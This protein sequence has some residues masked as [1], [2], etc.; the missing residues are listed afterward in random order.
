MLSQQAKTRGIPEL[1]PRLPLSTPEFLSAGLNYHNL[2]TDRLSYQA[3]NGPLFYSCISPDSPQDFNIQIESQSQF[4]WPGSNDALSAPVSASI[5]NSII[6]SGA[7]G[8]SSTL[9]PSIGTDEVGNITEN[10]TQ[11][12]AEPLQG[13]SYHTVPFLYPNFPSRETITYTS[14]QN[15]F[16]NQ[17]IQPRVLTEDL[18]PNSNHEENFPP[19][20][21]QETT[22]GSRCQLLEVDSM[23]S[24]QAD[25]LLDHS[26]K[27][28]TPLVPACP[29]TAD[30]YANYIQLWRG[31]AFT[32]S[33]YIAM[34][35]KLN[36][37]YIRSSDWQ[38]PFY[39]ATTT[40]EDDPATLLATAQ[41]PYAPANLQPTLP[42]ILFPHHAY[43][44]LIPFPVFRA[45]AITL[46]NTVHGPH[47]DLWDLKRD[48]NAGLVCWS[49]GNGT[50]GGNV[51]PWDVRSWKAAP[52]FLRKWRMLIE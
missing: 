36:I 13:T 35:L 39:R 41:V 26:V 42:Q 47:C 31:S 37:E 14:N 15:S 9:L 20:I 40:L 51:Q 8:F 43:L 3:V 38:S 5:P 22:T 18:F 11:N 52:W 6:D 48:I 10:S 49:P 21:Q 2:A 28:V 1:R 33:L 17:D 46:A 7:P 34:S 23:P 12:E 29:A 50:G 44:D 27:H 30:P 19:I 24:I 16:Q 25:P 4:E 45:R 32:A